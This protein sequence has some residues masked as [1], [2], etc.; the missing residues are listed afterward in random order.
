MDIYLY[1][2]LTFIVIVYLLG[3][4]KHTYQNRLP[5]VSYPFTLSIAVVVFFKVATFP[6]LEYGDKEV[7]QDTFN[8]LSMITLWESKDLGFYIFSYLIKSI[9]SD[10]Q[11]YFFILAFIYVFGYLVLANRF[12]KKELIGY[13]IIASFLSFG[14][15]SYGVNTIRA[16]VALSLFLVA[17]A[18]YNN[19]IKFLIISIIS[20]LIHKSLLL[21]FVAFYST[22]YITK[23]KYYYYFWLLCLIVSAINISFVFNFVQGLIGQSDNRFEGYLADETLERYNVGFRID[24]IL[25][26]LIPILIGRLYIL[27]YN[28]QDEWYQRMFHTYLLSNAIWLLV[29]RMAFTDRVAYLSWFLIPVI[30]LYPLLNHEMPI[31][32]KKWL[33]LILLG[34]HAFASFMYFK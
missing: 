10:S 6:V 13:F 17:L 9:I 22:K 20:V 26:S 1:F 7:Y 15:E 23:T 16:G 30:L 14:F 32:K 24:F 29:I 34:I 4:L 11:V 27:K 21:P 8:N 18:N 19:K 33:F 2:I 12:I 3:L 31:D 25:Y 5:T 28:V